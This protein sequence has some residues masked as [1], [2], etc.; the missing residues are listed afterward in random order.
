[1]IANTVRERNIE[2][3]YEIRYLLDSGCSACIAECIRFIS[4]MEKS[5][6]KGTITIYYSSS[7]AENLD[8]YLSQLRTPIPTNI[9]F[10]GREDNYPFKYKNLTRLH[11]VDINGKSLA[12]V[13]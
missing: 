7:F 8:Y 13:Q 9:S 2:E 10:V 3:P 4:E 11:I 1:M 5:K 6:Y 12:I